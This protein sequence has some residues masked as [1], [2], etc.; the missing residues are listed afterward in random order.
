MD[1]LVHRV[2]AAVPGGLVAQGDNNPCTDPT[3]VIADNMVGRVTHVARAGKIRSVSGGWPGL[4]HARVLRTRRC[5]WKRIWRLAAMVGRTPYRWLQD[6][7]LVPRIWRPKLTKVSLLTEDGLLVKYIC[8]QQTVARWWPAE[9]RFEC[10]K[11]YDLVLRFE[12]LPGEHV[13]DTRQ[14]PSETD[15]L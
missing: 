6:S 5:V 7:D 10:Q 8:G 1:D 9:N 14:V 13:D 11:P 12:K 2:V 15:S 4:V 3:L